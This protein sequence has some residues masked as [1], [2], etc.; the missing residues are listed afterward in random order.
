MKSAR[1]NPFRRACVEKVQYQFPTGF[2]CDDLIARLGPT[3]N[4]GALVGPEGSGKTTLLENLEPILAA[5]G[6]RVWLGRARPGTFLD[7]KSPLTNNDFLLV[8]SAEQLGW[9]EWQRFKFT[10]RRA[11]GLVVTSHQP[12]LLPTLWTCETTVELL[13]AIVCE[14]VCAGLRSEL[15]LEL[16]QLSALFFRH[17][18]N[19]RAVLRELYDRVALRED[20]R[21][22]VVS[23]SS[24]ECRV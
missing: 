16:D 24:G 19:I 3:E 11:G 20:I 6:Y 1:E 12:G 17:R 22:T 10:S 13:E 15:G 2:S 8:D 23:H 9:L 4:R 14:L 7:L 5:R 21:E 18:G